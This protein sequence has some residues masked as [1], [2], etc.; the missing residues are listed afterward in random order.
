MDMPTTNTNVGNTRSVGVKPFHCAWFI[1]P[2]EPGPP[3]LFT[4]IMNAMVMPRSTSS[5][6]SRCG[7]SGFSAGLAM[8]VRILSLGLAKDRRLAG[9]P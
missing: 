5:E 7:E 1:K 8:Y 6:S 2:H 4:M 3:L 9:C